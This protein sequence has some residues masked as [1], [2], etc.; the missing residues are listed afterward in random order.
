MMAL[1]IMLAWRDLV[2]GAEEGGIQ[3]DIGC[4]LGGSG[5]S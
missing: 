4:G 2:G 1:C 5:T 3:G